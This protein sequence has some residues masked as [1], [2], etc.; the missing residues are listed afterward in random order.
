MDRRELDSVWVD[1]NNPTRRNS[2]ETLSGTMHPPAIVIADVEPHV[3]AKMPKPETL[4]QT[5]EKRQLDV[6]P[7]AGDDTFEKPT[8]VSLRQR[9][10]HFTWAWFT[11]P[12]S[13][14][15]ISLLIHV[16]PYQFTGLRTIGMVV[17]AINIAIFALTCLAMLARFILYPDTI[18]KSVKHHREGFMFPTFFLAIATLIT[19]TQRYAMPVDDTKWIWATQT[20]FWAYVL[21]TLI[22]AIAQYIYLFAVHGFNLQTM[23]PGWILPIF[24]IM[25]TGTVST[26]IL[27]TQHNIDSLPFIVAGLTCQ[28]LGFMVSMMMYAHMV[29]RLMQSGLPN[30]EHRTGLF[31]CVG[32]PAFTA[33]ALI[34]MANRLPQSIDGLVIDVA[35]IRAAALMAAV[36]LWA[37]SFWWFF[38]AA[39]SVVMSPPEFFHLGWW[40]LVFPNTGFTLA[41]ISIGTEFHSAG[42]LWF[43]TA[44]S[45]LVIITFC[46]VFCFNVRAV[47]V[48]DI[49]YPGKDED[50]D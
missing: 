38:I 43:S 35:T 8:K 1:S 11:L 17:Y 48:R 12:M 46:V 49:M 32:P 44:M 39:V 22:L 47:L 26:V 21:V 23:M 13:S 33:L 16:Q 7:E 42:I 6:D 30:R 2:I 3:N 24:P 50:A 40:P 25:L 15:G 29:G 18:I 45:I 20:I 36:F 9:L 31:M 10:R 4:S 28:G 19:S 27:E 37:L 41:T 34:G 14:G 5:Y